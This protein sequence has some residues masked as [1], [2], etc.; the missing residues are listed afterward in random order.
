MYSL[1]RNSEIINYYLAIQFFSILLMYFFQ[2]EE[3]SALLGLSVGLIILEGQN[4]E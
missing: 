4:N 2:A 1:F 3:L